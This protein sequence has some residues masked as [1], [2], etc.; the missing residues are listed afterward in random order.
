M[1]AIPGFGA[2][3]TFVLREAEDAMY[4]RA[5]AQDTNARS[6]V[7]AGGGLLG[8]EAAY[9]LL[10]LGLRVTVLERGRWPLQRQVD[11]HGGGFLRDYL[12]GLGIQVFVE[13]EV[14]RLAVQDGLVREAVLRDARALSCDVFL[15]CAGIRPNVALAAEAGLKVNRGVVVDKPPAHECAIHLLCRRLR[16]SSAARS[17]ASGRRAWSRA[18][19]QRRTRWAKTASTPAPCGPRSSRSSAPISPRWVAS[20]RTRRT[21]S[22]M[23]EDPEAHRYAKLVVAGGRIAGA[24]ILG[25]PKE[26]GLVA[27]AL[28]SGRDV[29]RDLARLRVGDWS[30]FEPAGERAAA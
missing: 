6:A 19:L 27:E 17:T 7:V 26:A 28:K 23:F 20:P 11:E 29:S 22:I 18:R 13:S 16:R 3:G 10:K 8:L 15:V 25:F 4:I 12:A 2:A 24:I 5:Y 1:P 9:A 30:V 21:R 14:A